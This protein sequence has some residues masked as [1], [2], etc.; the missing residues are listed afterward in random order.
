MAAKDV[1]FGDTARAR[2]I[3]GVNVLAD[4]VKVT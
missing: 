2:M 1:K 4:A 3:A